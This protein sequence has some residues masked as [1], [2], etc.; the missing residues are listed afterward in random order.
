MSD[1]EASSIHTP[2][3]T[4]PHHFTD[5]PVIPEDYL[6]ELEDRYPALATATRALIYVRN[7]AN[8]HAIAKRERRRMR[9]FLQPLRDTIEATYKSAFWAAYNDDNAL[10]PQPQPTQ[11]DG[12][13]M[14]VM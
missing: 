9:L 12:D 7:P 2:V 13:L 10:F 11:G 4:H 14:F 6:F 1:D 5:L 8:A 3:M